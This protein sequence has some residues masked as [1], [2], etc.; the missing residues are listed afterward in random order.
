MLDLI[1]L[2][3]DHPV[4]KVELR[5][6]A[7][8]LGRNEGSDIPLNHATLSGRHCRLEV[9]GDRVTVF[10]LGS[11]NGTYID[12]QRIEEA[13]LQVGQTLRLGDLPMQLAERRAVRPPSAL[14]LEAEPPPFTLVD[15]RPACAAHHQVPAVYRCQGCHRLCCDNCVRHVHLAG[16]K[17]RL[18]C[19]HCSSPCELLPGATA[20]TR[21]ISRPGFFKTMRMRFG[22]KHDEE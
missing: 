12:D 7:S 20:P 15:G 8:T 19:P 10:D 6:G 4:A 17:N 9:A 16:G 13:E 5:D 3:P 2:N 22:R 14:H 18:S 11:T 1:I 21:P